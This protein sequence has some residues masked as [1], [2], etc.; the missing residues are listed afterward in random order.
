MLRVREHV[1]RLHVG[2]PVHPAQRLQVACLRGGVAA[3]IYYPLRSGLHYGL[4]HVGVHP[5]AR[6]VGD[7]DIRPAMLRDELRREYVLHV[8]GEE[9][10][11]GDSVAGGVRL[12]VLDCFGHI[13]H[14]D[15]F[16]G[17]GTYELGYRACTGVEVVYRLCTGERGELACGAVELQR[18]GVV[19]LVER[20]GP[21]PEAQALHGL[22]DRLVAAV[23]YAFTVGDAVVELVV[24]DIV[25]RGNLRETLRDRIQH[26]LTAVEVGGEAYYQHHLSVV[27]SA[28][29]HVAEDA[30]VLPYIVEGYAVAYRI[31]PDE[32]A[33]VVGGAALQVALVDIEHLVEELAHM[34][35]EP[36]PPVCGN[37]PEGFGGSL[38][39]GFGGNIA[40]R[41]SGSAVGKGSG[42]AVTGWSFGCDFAGEDPALVRGGE[43]QLVAV[44]LGLAGRDDGTDLG[45]FE[46]SC[47]RELVEDLPLLG[48][49]L[50][51][52]GEQLP[53]A[54]SADTEM[55]AEWLQPVG[56]GLHQAHYATFEVVLFLYRN[57]DVD[58]ISRHGVFYEHDLPL[59]GVRDAFALRGN[60]LHGQVFKYCLFLQS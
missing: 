38:D 45:E 40:I 42:S 2:Y 50:H 11:V 10:A 26:R 18:L 57:P 35:T 12:R 33:Y 59:R 9:A 29:E 48:L 32:Q 1:H 16:G 25:E 28:Y 54:A 36:L 24:Y 3:D 58:D 23:E 30:A 49:Q 20:L 60:A 6:R 34:E 5:C 4:Y 8:A 14:S 13:F 22:V 21:Y 51:A 46:M 55:F 53:A 43:L 56:R 27:G 15:D 7:Y 44:E 39:G 31:F 37:V 19:G 52:I 17:P 47:A 41:R